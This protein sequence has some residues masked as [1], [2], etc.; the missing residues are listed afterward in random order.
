VIVVLLSAFVLGP[1]VTTQSLHGY[2]SGG[3]PFTYAW[4][5]VLLFPAHKQLPGVFTMTP[6]TAAV[7]GSLW[8]LASE[9]VCYAIVPLLAL[10]GLRRHGRVTS[11]AWVGVGLVGQMVTHGTAP[12][13][14]NFEFAMFFMWMTFFAAGAAVYA[15]SLPGRGVF[16]GRPCAGLWLLFFLSV[17]TPFANVLLLVLVPYT[18]F[19]IAFADLGRIG[20]IAIRRDLSYG[21]YLYAFPI[22]QLVISWL[23]GRL[24]VPP[25]LVFAIALPLT[26]GCAMASWH[27]VEEPCLRL[28][29]RLRRSARGQLATAA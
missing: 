25:L 2:F 7:N 16:A 3:E 14:G 4:S 19:T 20:T 23:G 28:K 13:P 17:L 12:I 22:Q 24:G 11:L 18:V 10:I 15:F 5:N 1:I 26:A 29:R 9:V 8:T 6:Y 21:I 27:L